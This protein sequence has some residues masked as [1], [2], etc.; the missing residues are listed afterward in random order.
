MTC[1]VSHRINHKEV[2]LVYAVLKTKIWL[3]TIIVMIATDTSTII[4][5][6][7][8]R[9]SKTPTNILPK[10]GNVWLLLGVMSHETTWS[11]LS[12]D[13]THWAPAREG[14]YLVLLH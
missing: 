2:S 7:C 10:L 8:E 1:L 14:K 13:L 6:I 5:V 9:Q 3:A 4:A 12:F 11:S